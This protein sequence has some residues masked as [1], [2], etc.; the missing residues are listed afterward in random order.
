M[1][2][3]PTA[4]ELPPEF[5]VQFMAQS[6]SSDE[7]FFDQHLLCAACADAYI[8]GLPAICGDLIPPPGFDFVDLLTTRYGGITEIDLNSGLPVRDGGSSTRPE[9]MWELY[10]LPWLCLKEA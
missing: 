2:S 6:R 10:V 5:V 8:A 4:C 1:H 9:A 3:S 7:R